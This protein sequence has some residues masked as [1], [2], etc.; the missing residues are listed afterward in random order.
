MPHHFFVPP[1]W[2]TPPRVTLYDET[3]R[4]IRTVLRM[5]PDDELVILD[6]S[7]AAWRVRLTE[8]SKSTIQ[9]E[10]VETVTLD[11]EPQTR[12]R[13]YQGVLKGQKFEWVLQKCTELGVT[14][15]VPL[16]TER[17]I[18][19]NRTDLAKKRVRWQRIIQEAAEQ[20][21]RARLPLLHEAMSLTEALSAAGQLNL[22]AWEEASRGETIS[23]VLA[24]QSQLDIGLFIGSEG[25]FSTAEAQQARQA[26][27]KLV[28]L[29]PRI[30]RA[31]TASLVA[32]TIILHN[33]A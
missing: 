12:L 32:S 23:Q 21:K 2:L 4:Q 10:L 24:S 28:T 18:I 14:E 22:L 5:Q 3:A 27:V 6:N 29:G 7:G 33:Q 17:A 30:L 13:L 16:L 19:R 11:T 31:E 1:T 8:F 26:D 15:F 9:G 20:S 25:G